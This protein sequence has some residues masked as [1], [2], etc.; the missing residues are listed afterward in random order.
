MVEQ[1]W[2]K[3]LI[4]S[5]EKAGWISLPQ[6]T[7]DK[8]A[9]LIGASA[10]EVVAADST[11]VNL[12]KVVSVALAA[13]SDRKVVMSARGNFPTDL[14][15]VQGLLAQLGAGHELLTIDDV[16][17]DLEAALAQHGANTAAVVLTHVDYVTGRMFDMARLTAAA[18]GVGALMIWDLAH[19]IGAVP[20]DVNA[21]GVDFAVGCGYKYLNAGPGAP[22]FVYVARRH[23]ELAQ[24]LSG[25]MGHAQ[26]FAF[27]ESYHPAPGIARYLCG[28][29]SVIGMSALE[30]SVDLMLEAPMAAIRRKSIAL[31]EAF[32]ALA[33]E[34]CEGPGLRLLTPRDASRRGSQLSYSHPRS[35]A[36]MQE[37]EAR[38]VIGDCREPDVLRFG[39]APLYV[40]YVDVWDAVMD[41][42][43]AIAPGKP[44]PAV[45]AV[46]S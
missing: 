14:Y 22:A 46:P 37:L 6:R 33:D 4:G 12:Y 15:M 8:L 20:L 19:S 38:G 3:G 17:R 45:R 25:W 16:E 34:H 30:A 40:R 9:R 44:R 11:S 32:M 41:L 35:R 29:P 18:H 1:E 21:C 27:S 10:G 2:A 36:I 42:A 28:T 24:P 26:P 31:A 13:R 43:S 5:W 23:Q 7:G 39:F